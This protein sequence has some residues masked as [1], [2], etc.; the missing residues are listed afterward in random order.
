MFHPNTIT[1]ILIVY[2]LLVIA[3]PQGNPRQLNYPIRAGYITKVT[4]WWGAGVTRDL[5]VPG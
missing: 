2:L 5:G 4:S 1:P 3:S